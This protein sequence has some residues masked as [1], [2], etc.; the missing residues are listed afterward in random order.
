MTVIKINHEIM[1]M[2]QIA[3]ICHFCNFL[4]LQMM[5]KYISILF[6]QLN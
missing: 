5:V 2:L 6:F 1:K 3:T 4:I